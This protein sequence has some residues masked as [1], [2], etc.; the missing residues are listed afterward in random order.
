MKIALIGNGK[1]GKLIEELALSQGHEI[2]LKISRQGPSI[3][4]LSSVDV[5]IDF[6]HSSGVLNNI[7]A[8]ASQKKPLVIGTTGWDE[9]LSEAKKVVEKSGIGCVYS[10]NFSIGVQ[11]FLQIVAYAAQLINPFHEYDVGGIE[12]HHRQKL[13][14]PSGT[15]KAIAKQIAQQMQRPH[16]LEFASVRCGHVPGTHT[17]EFDSPHDTITLSHQARN[18][19]GFAKG[20]LKAAEWIV[21]KKG[22][23]TMEDLIRNIG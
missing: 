12:I 9:H 5:G 3:K 23:Y 2:V 16:A 22:F 4:E 21:D 18:R 20:A 19:E 1:M 11:A 8:F 13:D 15:A 6:S 10:P 17:I 14:S 7:R